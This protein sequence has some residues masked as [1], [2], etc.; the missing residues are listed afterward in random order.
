LFPYIYIIS[1]WGGQRRRYAATKFILYTAAASI[2]ILVAALAM[3]LYG[4]GNI[5]FDLTSLALK[6]YPLGLQ[7]LLYGALF[8]AFG[9]KLAIFPLHT[10]L[11]DAHSEASSPV[12]MILAGV[13]LKMGGYGLTR[14][15][16]E[17]LPYAHV[18]FGPVI[19]VL[20]VVN[21]IYGALK[22]FAQTNMKRCLAFSSISHMGFV[23]LGLAS[24]TYVGMNGL[25]Y[26]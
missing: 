21:I 13:W 20:G 6:D 25:C 4:G 17:L 18:Y 12:S 8:I 16:M 1:I 15:S 9:V 10:W 2:F 22:S 19:V 14:L 11:P 5:S 3:G 23:L 24:F 26:Q 7:L